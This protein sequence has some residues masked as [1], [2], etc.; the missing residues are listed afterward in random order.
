M[1]PRRI[2]QQA[3]HESGY[4]IV[5]L[6]VVMMILTVV[7]SALTVLF[8]TG[9]HSQE[10]LT[11]RFQ[12]QVQLNTAVNKLRR[13][14]HT[15]C[16][17]AGGY[18]TSSITFEDP[19]S[20][21]FQ[22]PTTPC[23]SPTFVTWCTIGSGT[24]YALYRTPGTVCTATGGHRYADY[25]ANKN[26]FPHYTADSSANGEL[27]QLQIDFPIS[28]AASAKRSDSYELKDFIVLR[29]STLS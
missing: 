1:V 12:A 26:V 24:R 28:V 2:A 11:A 25:I 7:M 20:G 22:P 13:E 21:T 16:G 17:L 6:L 9:M 5:E 8:T 3:R 10:D 15:A 29:N 14:A 4:T 23:T 18:T 27:A 19:A